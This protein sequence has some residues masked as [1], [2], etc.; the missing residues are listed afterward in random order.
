MAAEAWQEEHL[1]VTYCPGRSGLPGSCLWPERS[2]LEGPGW[3]EQPGQ[4]ARRAETPA[5]PL[6]LGVLKEAPQEETFAPGILWDGGG[7]PS[8]GLKGGHLPTSLDQL[9]P[10]R[11]QGHAGCPLLSPFSGHVKGKWNHSWGTCF[12]RT[13]T[14][15]SKEGWKPLAAMLRG[16]IC[17]VV[18]HGSEV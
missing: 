2:H 4:L 1:S 11:V 16:E 8:Q 5:C 13:V 15:L 9:S 7:G 6:S 3:A 14:F 10:K 17:W 18:E 12:A